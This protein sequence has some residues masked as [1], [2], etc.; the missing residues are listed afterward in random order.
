MP[1]YR[2]DLPV[3]V[4][5]LIEADTPEGALTSAL[6]M[7]MTEIAITDPGFS[8]CGTIWATAGDNAAGAP[9]VTLADVEEDEDEA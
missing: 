5:A 8:G 6:G 9:P 7:H 4:T 3:F 1:R 2:V